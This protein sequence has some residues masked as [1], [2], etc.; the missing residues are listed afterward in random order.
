MTSADHASGTD[1]VAEAAGVEPGCTH[2]INI[3]GDEPLIDPGLIDELVGALAA[4]PETPMV[5]AA[6][7]AAGGEPLDDPNIVKTV[8][9]KCGEALYFSRSVIPHPG[10]HHPEAPRFRHKGIYGYTRDFLLQFVRWRPSPLEVAERLEQLRA[11]ENGA[12]IKVVICDDDSIGVDT[13]A[14]A[15]QVEQLILAA[16]APGAPQPET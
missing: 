11:L 10:S 16:R 7:P 5:T 1:R 8:L 15:E 4:D 9:N 3:Q 2:V 13:P 12:R 6:V 14:Q